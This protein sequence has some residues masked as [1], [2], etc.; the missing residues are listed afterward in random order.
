MNG[1]GFQLRNRRLL[2]ALVQICFWVVGCFMIVLK[3]MLVGLSSDVGGEP[4]E[5][6]VKH[7]RRIQD[8]GCM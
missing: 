7:E 8:L 5:H 4:H 2:F 6:A 3:V 1:Q